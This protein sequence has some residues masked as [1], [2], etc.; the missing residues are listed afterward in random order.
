MRDERRLIEQSGRLLGLEVRILGFLAGLRLEGGVDVGTMLVLLLGSMLADMTGER[1]EVVR[2]VEQ[3]VAGG[4]ALQVEA[5]EEGGRLAKAR[6][7]RCDIARSAFVFIHLNYGLLFILRLHLCKRHL[8]HTLR[9]V[10]LRV[11]SRNLLVV[12][13]L[14]LLCH[15]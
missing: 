2:L 12:F 6:L 14:I 5:L 1:G 15:T 8:A 11:R 10:A 9:H 3:E 13:N 4:A 7:H